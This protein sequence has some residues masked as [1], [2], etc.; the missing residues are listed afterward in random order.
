MIQNKI[1]IRIG[2]SK[3]GQMQGPIKTEHINSINTCLRQ[4]NHNM[5]AF[6]RKNFFKIFSML[7]QYN[8]WIE[9]LEQCRDNIQNCSE[10]AGCNLVEFIC[11]DNAITTTTHCANATELDFFFKNYNIKKTQDGERLLSEALAV[12][13]I[14]L[15]RFHGNFTF[16]VS[17]PTIK[18]FKSCFG[19]Y[20]RF[21]NLDFLP[22]HIFES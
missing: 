2:T 17:R 12:E 22:S 10:E 20:I 19:I 15:M 3:I 7:H 8:Y 9:I 11:L 5:W 6:H 21:P 1:F 14:E 13:L 16:V 18:F 4:L